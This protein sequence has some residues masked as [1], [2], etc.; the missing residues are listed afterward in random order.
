MN[1]LE[2]AGKDIKVLVND[3]LRLTVLRTDGGLLWESS[4]SQ[5]PTVEVRTGGA[6]SRRM[7]L[8]S[9]AHVPVSAF[10]DGKYQGHTVRLDP[11]TGFDSQPESIFCLKREQNHS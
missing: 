10:D 7:L 3:N 2:L 9:A 8:S 1:Q 4:K 6:D 5:M 11:F